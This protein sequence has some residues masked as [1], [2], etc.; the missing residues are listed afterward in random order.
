MNRGNKCRATGLLLAASLLETLF[1]IFPDPRE[2]PMEGGD[3]LPDAFYV[4]CAGVD[5]L[6]L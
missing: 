1:L 6:I 5:C 2:V 3:I 4:D